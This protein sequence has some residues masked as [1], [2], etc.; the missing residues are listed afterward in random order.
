MKAMRYHRFGGPELIQ[1]DEVAPP[2][3]APGDVVIRMAATSVNGA[4]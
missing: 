3:A 1:E 2:S 4:D